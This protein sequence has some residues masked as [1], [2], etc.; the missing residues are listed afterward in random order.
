[1]LLLL[2]LHH[3]Q[4]LA[5]LLAHRVNFRLDFADLATFS[6]ISCFTWLSSLAPDASSA[7][8]TCSTSRCSGKYSGL[9]RP[10]ASLINVSSSMIAPARNLR[11]SK[12]ACS[13]GAGILGRRRAARSGLTRVA[14]GSVHVGLSVGLQNSIEEFD[15]VFSFNVPKSESR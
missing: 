11:S 5:N 3:R 10:A 6:A 7:T 1:M 12:S 14:E 4:Q 15:V 8:T 9:R 2:L 13:K